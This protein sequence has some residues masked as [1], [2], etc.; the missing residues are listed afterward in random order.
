MKWMP[1]DF[2]IGFDAASL[3][4]LFFGK[5]ALNFGGGI[6]VLINE[7]EHFT[8]EPLGYNKKLF[9]EAVS[10]SGFFRKFF[11]ALKIATKSIIDRIFFSGRIQVSAFLK[12]GDYY[13]YFRLRD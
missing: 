4:I 10:R 2:D 6:L 5:I 7:Y 9:D 3:I 12:S 11:E 1:F 8:S 13:F